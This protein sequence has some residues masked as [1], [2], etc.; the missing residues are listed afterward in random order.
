MKER[1]KVILGVALLTPLLVLGATM[2]VVAHEGEDHSQVAQT[3][4]T[5]AT[6]ETET[7]VDDPPT[8]TK[9][10]ERLEKRKAA[11]NTRLTTA[12]KT[13]VTTRCKA[14]Q[15]MVSSVSRR[16]KGVE[17]SRT[18]VYGNLVDRLTKLSDKL[19]T[20]G[21]DTTTLNTQIDE[22]KT[23]I[24][25]F[26]TDLAEYHQTVA[27]LAA[28]DCTAD[29]TAFQA[30]LDAARTA[31]TKVADDAKAIKTYLSETIKPTLVQLRSKVATKPETE[32]EGE[33]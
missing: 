24:A 21:V 5:E 11:L 27:D 3:T 15:G 12:Q 28:L 9:L 2:P 31:R 26:N 7:E 13:R 29:P 8:P 17:T 22:L 30:S 25:T 19:K 33:N 16:I 23:K 10:K 4:T 14:A 18:Q 20:S 1:I 32:N 6:T